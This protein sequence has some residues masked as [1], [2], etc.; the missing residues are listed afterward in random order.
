MFRISSILLLA[1]IVFA[2]LNSQSVIWNEEFNLAD[3]TTSG[4]AGKWTSACTSCVAGDW[5]EVR[6]GKFEAHDVNDWA[7]WQSGWIDIAGC[8]DV[9]ITLDASETGD[10]EGPGCNCS[11]N[12]DY[13]DVFHQ[14]NTGPWILL[15]DWNGDGES[16]HTLSGDSVNG[17]YND[18]DWVF[19]TAMDTPST[20]D[21]V[22]IRVEFRNSEE[23]EK[24]M[25]DN[26]TVLGNCA[27]PRSPGF[28]VFES[29]NSA[30]IHWNP[31]EFQGVHSFR[32]A[33]NKNPDGQLEFL[34]ANFSSGKYPDYP[35]E[36]GKWQ[37]LLQWGDINGNFIESEAVEIEISKI[38]NQTNLFCYQIS[39]SIAFSRSAKHD[40]EI[41]IS[42]LSGRILLCTTLPAG[43]SKIFAEGIPPGMYLIQISEGSYPLQTQLLRKY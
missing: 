38:R 28:T 10:H 33:R 23:N 13:F 22:R 6:S 36:N 25:L 42:D 19:T 16:G 15:E 41:R 20:G 5:L 12:I 34:P 27:L 9:V 37:Y 17:S 3:G 31:S 26:V 32:I 29:G 18:S 1:I 40:T 7:Y 39:E 4:S 11:I 30:E 2:K 8:D 24:M 35:P 43:E 21:S 14:V